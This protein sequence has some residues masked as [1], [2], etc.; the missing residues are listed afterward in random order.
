MNKCFGCGTILS[1]NKD[2]EG[3]T[4]NI[5]NNLCERCFRIR[6]YNDYKLIVKD[7]NNYVEILKNIDSNYLVIL[8]VDL[9]N[10]NDKLNDISKYLN[11]KILLV[12]TKYDLMPSNNEEKFKSFFNKYDLNIIDTV[13]ISS[14]N[15]YNFDILYD[16]IN[17]YRVS[18]K[19]YVVGFTN[20]GKS[21]MINKLIYNYSNNIDY[22]TTSNL[23]STTLNTIEIK[24]N[25]LVIIDTPGLLD[26]SIVNYIDSDL[27]K[28]VIPKKKIKPITYQIKG[29]QIISIENIVRIDCSDTNLTIYMSNNLN[30]NRYYKK[31]NFNKLIKHHLCVNKNQDIVILGLGFIHVSNDSVIDIYV[32]DNTSVFVREALIGG[33]YEKK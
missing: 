17:T 3:Y 26:N 32:I 24:I 1:S 33:N 10:V 30:I 25:D 12:L 2:E 6:N 16:K 9:L 21:S 18:N 31:I 5:N 23:P 20:A 22:I 13:I 28:K 27:I 15:N 11:N 7:N 29:R 4:S 8:V 14:N 19:V